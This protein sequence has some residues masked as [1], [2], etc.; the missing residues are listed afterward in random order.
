MMNV[1]VVE[2]YFSYI[3]FDF[4]TISLLNN[5]SLSPPYVTPQI[6]YMD[7]QEKRLYANQVV[8]A[9]TYSENTGFN[10]QGNNA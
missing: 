8:W 9:R 3:Q 4:S 10:S 2:F 7:N 6:H 1:L 5:Y